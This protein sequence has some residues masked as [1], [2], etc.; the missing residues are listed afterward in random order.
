MVV[1]T[2]VIS[3]LICTVTLLIT[4]FITTHEPPSRELVKGCPSR[5][6]IVVPP[7]R[8]KVTYPTTILPSTSIK[9]YLNIKTI[10]LGLLIIIIV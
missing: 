7:K 2:G 3:P 4:P 10:F 1:I 9:G 6:E 8:L 5:K